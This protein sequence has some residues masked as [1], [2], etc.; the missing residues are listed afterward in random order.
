MKIQLLRHATLLIA[1]NGKKILVDPML[2]PAGGMA[3]FANSLNQQRNPLVALNMKIDFDQDI[4]SVLLTHTHSDHFDESA[5]QQ[6]PAHTTILCQPEDEEKL[7]QL[8]FLNI[9]PIKDEYYWEGIKLIRVGGQHGTGEIG[10]RMGPVSGYVLQVKGEPSLYIAGDTIYCAEVAQ[11]LTLYQPR[12]VVVNA[13]GARFDSGDPITMT[14][15]DVVKV[16]R[17]GEAQIVA[18]HMEAINHCLV[19]RNDLR[20]YLEQEGVITQVFIPVDGEELNF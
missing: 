19:S 18:V 9:Q 2:G 7:Q 6:I 10:L 20:R 16:C 3:P 12:V 1:I 13:G 8:G 15:E 5:I 4:D 14:A 11:V 17:Q